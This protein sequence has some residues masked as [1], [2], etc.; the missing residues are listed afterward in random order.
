VTA[1]KHAKRLDIVTRSEQQLG[2]AA[3]IVIAH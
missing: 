1:V 2:V 3:G